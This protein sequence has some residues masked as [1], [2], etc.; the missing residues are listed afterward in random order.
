MCSC[1]EDLTQHD[2][3]FFIATINCVLFG[4]EVMMTAEI[5]SN[6]RIGAPDT[7]RTCDPPLRSKFLGAFPSIP[8]DIFITIYLC[9]SVTYWYRE[10]H[11][12]ALIYPCFPLKSCT[13][14]A[15]NRP[16]PS[17]YQGVSG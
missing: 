2:V 9:K 16:K 15:Q 10:I 12:D 14:V 1:W 7:N 11:R 3:S 17:P 13:V 6:F 5:L 4:H 8:L